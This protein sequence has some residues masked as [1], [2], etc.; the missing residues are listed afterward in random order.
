IGAAL[1]RGVQRH[2]I[3]TSVKHFA[4]NNQEHERLRVSA[5]VDDR[6]LHEIYLRAFEYIV[7][8]EQPWTIMASYNKINGVY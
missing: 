8:T 4:V 1:V 7:R 5:D 6:P 2:G 3:G